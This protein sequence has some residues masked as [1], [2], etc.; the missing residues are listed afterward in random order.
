[1]MFIDKSSVSRQFP[2]N[3]R[4]EQKKKLE[5]S[6]THKLHNVN[7]TPKRTNFPPVEYRVNVASEYYKIIWRQLGNVENPPKSR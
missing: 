5:F 1:M 6:Q 3:H 7:E 2:L 4:L